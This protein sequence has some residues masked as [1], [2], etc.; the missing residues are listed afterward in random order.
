MAVAVVEVSAYQSVKRLAEGS[1]TPMVFSEF[2]PR[3]DARSRL[4]P[5]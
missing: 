2:F 5:I 1:L 4:K 3:A